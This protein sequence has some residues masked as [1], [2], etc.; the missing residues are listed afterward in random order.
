MPCWVGGTPLLSRFG[1]LAC[2]VSDPPLGAGN[3]RVAPGLSCRVRQYST[4]VAL[5]VLPGAAGQGWKRPWGDRPLRINAAAPNLS[6]GD[7]A[8]RLDTCRAQNAQRNW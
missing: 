8:S 3:G 1:L 4:M 2:F 6:L 7:Q 5:G